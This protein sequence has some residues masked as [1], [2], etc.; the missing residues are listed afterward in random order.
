MPFDV[1]TEDEN[2]L[3]ALSGQKLSMETPAA[4]AAGYYLGAVR[5]GPTR[6]GVLLMWLAVDALVAKRKTQKHA[7]ASALL[8]VGVDLTWLNLD[9]GRLVG[10]RGPI[11]HGKLHDPEILRLAYRDTEALARALIRHVAGIEGGWPAMPNATAF[12]LPLGAHLA[13]QEGQWETE[14]HE[15]GLPIVD[16]DPGPSNL[17][18]VDALLGGH[19]QWVVVEGGDDRAR[20]RLR[21]WS[22]LAVRS[23]DVDVTQLIVRVDAAGELPEGAEI[24]V[25]AERILVSPVMANPADEAAEVRLGYHL[26]RLVG[27][28]Q[29]MRLG[30]LS[31]GFGALLIELAGAWAAYRAWVVDLEM[32]PEFLQ[33]SPLR[34]AN[35]VDLGA[36]IGVVVAGD[37]AT[38]AELEGWLRDETVDAELRQ[39]V[40]ALVEHLRDAR[41][42]QDVLGVI[43]Q[44]RDS[45]ASE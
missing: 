42:F 25:N 43:A 31:E 15:H 28:M 40:A 1:T 29:V 10:V 5:E 13:E 8:E 18:R 44:I 27:A 6:R 34:G 33:L 14:W 16:D 37:D 38:A 21:F 19:D 17:P 36:Y 7:V 3:A 20:E 30:V 12:R 32:P 35:M 9:L 39:V 41:Q 23:L 45:A 24:V 26:C 2:A 11:A 22:M 4:R